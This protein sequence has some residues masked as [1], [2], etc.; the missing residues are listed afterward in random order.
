M[1]QMVAIHALLSILRNMRMKSVT[2]YNH[3]SFDIIH[4]LRKI[5]TSFAY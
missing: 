4:I 3:K 5:Q 2:I 1:N